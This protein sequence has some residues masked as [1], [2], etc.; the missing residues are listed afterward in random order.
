MNYLRILKIKVKSKKQICYM[1][2]VTITG[3]HNIHNL[4]KNDE[5]E[6]TRSNVH[7]EEPKHHNQVILLN[8]CYMGDKDEMILHVKREITRKIYGYKSQDIKKKIFDPTLLV[9]F[10][11]V[12][13]KLVA[14]KL[15]C[16]YCNSDLKVLFTCVRD[17][18]QWTLDRVN[19]DLCHSSSNTVICCLKCNL[20][21]RVMDVDKF[22]FTKQLKIKKLR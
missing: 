7:Y 6:S 9:T 3:K 2:T 18:K 16:I 13:E 20:Q 19:N 15:R 11:N 12:L 10:P 8:K 5:E 21:R 4:I 14:S 1:K 17:E 22:T